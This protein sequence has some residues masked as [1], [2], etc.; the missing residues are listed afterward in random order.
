M[1]RHLIAACIMGA[2]VYAGP[3]FG[4][5]AEACGTEQTL[6][7]HCTF[8]NGAK[9]VGVCYSDGVVSYAF[10]PDFVT[11]ELSLNRP[12]AQVDYTPFAW[13]SN[14][15]FESVALTN[16]DTVY[17]VFAATKRGPYDGVTEGGITVTPPNGQYVTLTCDAGSVWPRDPFDGIGKLSEIL[18]K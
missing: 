17:E 6:L 15:I 3:S 5:A 2:T 14:T 11:P 4:Q 13:A 8:G 7:F 18:D 12:L 9:Q 10:G 16:V 1:Q